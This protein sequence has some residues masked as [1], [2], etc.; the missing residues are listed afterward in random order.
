M[1]DLLLLAVGRTLLVIGGDL[2]VRGAVTVAEKLSIPP[3]IIGL[4]IVSLGTSA[5]E[6]FISV[7]AA[8]E[9]SG[10]LAIG[11]VVGS[12]IAN[13]LMVLGI[14]ALIRATSCE[15]SGVSRSIKIMIAITVIFM[16]MIFV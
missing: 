3:L 4:T 6:L 2:L 10:G 8:L 13:V 15:D 1:L 14:P 5:P 16:V 11:N 9:D 7:Q 12:N